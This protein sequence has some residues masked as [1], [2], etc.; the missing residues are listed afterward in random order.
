MDGYRQE[1]EKE[2]A[3]A[4]QHRQGRS[5]AGLFVKI[6]QHEEKTPRGFDLSS[7]PKKG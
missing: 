4:N 3:Q 5:V 1:D 7:N 2:Q 6:V